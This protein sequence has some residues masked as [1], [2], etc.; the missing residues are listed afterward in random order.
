M[1]AYCLGEKHIIPKQED[2]ISRKPWGLE[3]WGLFVWLVP[4]MFSDAAALP[5]F[6]SIVR[7]SVINQFWIANKPV[8][9]I[10]FQDDM[11]FD[12]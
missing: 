5:K 7:I 8:S 2:F 4:L 12:L 6:W 3:G 11:A 9:M 10:H 1:T